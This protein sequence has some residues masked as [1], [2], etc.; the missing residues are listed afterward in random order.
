MVHRPSPEP[1]ESVIQARE[2]SRSRG[3]AR[4]LRS[5]VAFTWNDGAIQLER[6]SHPALCRAVMRHVAGIPGSR[7]VGSPVVEAEPAETA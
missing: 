6:G 5:R 3:T 7:N 1:E 2:V 4:D